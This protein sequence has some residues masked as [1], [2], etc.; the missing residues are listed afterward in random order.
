M[1]DAE[2]IQ[3]FDNEKDKSLKIQLQKVDGLEKCIVIILSGYV[4]TY[5]ST[6]FQKRVTTLID[7][8]YIQIIFNC[9]SK[10][11]KRKRWRYCIIKSSAEGL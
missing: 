10:G 5:N 6:F 7:A 8:G 9:F 3:S 1:N 11:G 2:I 4:D